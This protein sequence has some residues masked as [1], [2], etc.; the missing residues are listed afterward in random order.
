MDGLKP[1]LADGLANACG[2]Y[3]FDPVFHG[4]PPESSAEFIRGSGFLSPAR[5]KR[6]L[7]SGGR[8]NVVAAYDAGD[9]GLGE[10][11]WILKTE[12]P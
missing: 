12:K 4:R 6:L 1:F 8:Q 9:A 3:V 2:F 11:E 5:T 10:V 7:T